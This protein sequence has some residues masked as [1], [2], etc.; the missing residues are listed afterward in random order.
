M[1]VSILGVILSF[2]CFLMSPKELRVREDLPTILV[3]LIAH[4]LTGSL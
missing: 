4:S 2:S 3:A 1:E